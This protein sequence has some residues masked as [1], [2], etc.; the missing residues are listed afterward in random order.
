MSIG[1]NGQPVRATVIDYYQSMLNAARP[2]ATQQCYAIS[3]CKR[4]IQGHDKI[5]LPSFQGTYLNHF[6]VHDLDGA[7]QHRMLPVILAAAQEA[8]DAKNQIQDIAYGML[9]SQG[10]FTNIVSNAS[11]YASQA[12]KMIDY[13]KDSKCPKHPKLSCWDCGGDHSWMK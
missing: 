1:P 8:E 9:T 4:F 10:F 3:V 2:F 13:Y 6:V 11:A 5:L 7:Y 12:E